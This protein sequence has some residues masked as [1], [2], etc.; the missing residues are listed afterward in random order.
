MPPNEE[1]RERLEE[2]IETVDE[3]TDVPAHMLDRAERDL[4]GACVAKRWL[5]GKLRFTRTCGSGPDSEKR[6][7]TISVFSTNESGWFGTR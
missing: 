4:H 7:R 1:R 5:N 6:T 3:A 2:L